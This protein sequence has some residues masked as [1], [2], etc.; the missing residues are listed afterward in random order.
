MK[1][2]SKTVLVGLSGLLLGATVILGIRFLTYHEE[3]IHYHANFAVYING[4]REAFKNKIYYTETACTLET[5]IT[6][7]ERAHMHDGIN[8]VVHV[9][10]HAVT[11]GQFFENLGW[12]V[13]P[14]FIQQSDDTL[15]KA[16][17][18]SKLNVLIN[19][20]DY[21]GLGALT[22]M[23]IHDKDKVLV[24]YGAENQKDLETQFRTIAS[25]ATKY[26]TA[27][28]PAS[29]SSNHKTTLKDRLKHLL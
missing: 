25:T 15:Y 28:D 5:E 14:D 9:E 4:Q 1:V 8:D 3:S 20:Q 6:P 13:G 23:V 21:T 24:S 19:G 29:C 27:Q 26:D 10:D 2:F 7:M 16:D 12:Y 18:T 17:D 22:N 11:W